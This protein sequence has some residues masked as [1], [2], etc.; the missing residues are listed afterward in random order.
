MKLPGHLANAAPA[1]GAPAP[2]AGLDLTVAARN[3]RAAGGDPG[4]FAASLAA[5][6]RA[7]ASSEH[8]I[9]LAGIAAWRAGALALRDDALARTDVLR[10]EPDG[11]RAVAAVLGLG[12]DAIDE[13]VERQRADRFWWPG[14][15]ANRGY[16][17]A[18]GGFSGLGGAWVVPPQGGYALAEPGAFAILSGDEWWRL[19]ADVWGSRLVRVDDEPGAEASRSSA[20]IVCLADSYVAWVRVEDAA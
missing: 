12:D 7:D 8:A 9:A 14:R 6:Q 15:T 5:G 4:R 1:A 2:I 3:V 10:A 20:S 17:C 19:D 16:V 11:R 13:F 18:V